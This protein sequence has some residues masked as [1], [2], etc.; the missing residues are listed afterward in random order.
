MPH[1]GHE[2]HMR[3][4]TLVGSLVVTIML[5]LLIVKQQAAGGEF[6]THVGHLF[7]DAFLSRYFESDGSMREAKT[8]K[9]SLDHEAY[10]LINSNPFDQVADP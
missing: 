3:H 8:I 4:A 6:A 2:L 7:T 10:F 1:N 5:M 9:T